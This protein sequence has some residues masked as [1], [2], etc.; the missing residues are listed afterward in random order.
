MDE[1]KDE[2]EVKNLFVEPANGM[3]RI[4][5]NQFTLDWTASDIRIRFAELNVEPTVK[6]PGIKMVKIEERASVTITWAN[7]KYLRDALADAIV[8]Y[9]NVN[10]EI[11]TPLLPEYNYLNNFSLC[12]FTLYSFPLCNS[13][14]LCKAPPRRGGVDAPS[15]AKAQ[16]GWSDRRNVSAELTTI[17]ASPCRARA[18]RPAVAP[19]LLAEEGN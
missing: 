8:R 6:T 19:P 18:S 4:Y 1:K 11:K 16:T 2:R 9:E 15:E 17:E 3:L 13:L 7:A 12:R 14:P 5:G 10:G